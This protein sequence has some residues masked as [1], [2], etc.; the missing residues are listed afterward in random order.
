LER[1]AVI[2]ADRKAPMN[3]RCATRLYCVRIRKGGSGDTR[4]DRSL[5]DA[6]SD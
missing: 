6:A 3:F 2:V 1:Q 4:I 5:D